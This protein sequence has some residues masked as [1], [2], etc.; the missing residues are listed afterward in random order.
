[1]FL[2]LILSCFV[3]LWS[4]RRRLRGNPEAAWLVRYCS[5]V[6]TSLTAYAVSGAFLTAA[7]FDLFYHLV[8]FVILFK[9]LARAQGYVTDPV[10]VGPVD[11]RAPRIA[12]AS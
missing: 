4:L 10:R 3:S 12:T 11:A 2:L 5:M 9:A 8:S 1:V 6:E 7:Y